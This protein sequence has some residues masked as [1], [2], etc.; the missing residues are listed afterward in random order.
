MSDLGTH[1]VLNQSL[2]LE[3]YNAYTGDAALRES[4]RRHGAGWA[5]VELEAPLARPPKI[6]GVGLNYADHIAETGREPPEMTLVTCGCARTHA[7]A[8]CDRVVPSRAA[9]VS[10]AN[11]MSAAGVPGFA[12]CP[13][14]SLPVDSGLYA[15]CPSFSDSN[16][17]ESSFSS[18]R[19]VML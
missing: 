9:T 15:I 6:L 17:E 5:E 2:P 12:C 11:R 19:A 16:T 13:G 7:I 4:V 3:D 14:A 10:R 8:T 1:E 18:G